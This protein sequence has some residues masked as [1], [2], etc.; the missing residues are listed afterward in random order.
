VIAKVSDGHAI[1]IDVR[2]PG[3]WESGVVKGALLLPMSDFNGAR[4]R[5]AEFLATKDT[6]EVYVYC[7]SGARSEYVA[8][9]LREEGYRATN[10]GGYSRLKKAEVGTAKP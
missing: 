5:W 1:L 10:A 2:E 3:E 7:A 8:S 4:Q 9:K 6:K